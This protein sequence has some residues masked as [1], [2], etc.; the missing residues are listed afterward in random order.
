MTG[1]WVFF[2][3]LALFGFLATLF[4]IPMAKNRALRLGFVDYPGG[5][6]HHPEPVPLLG[7]ITF[8]FPL[9]CVLLSLYCINSLGGELFER[10][11]NFLVLSLLLGT[12]WILMLGTLD[13]KYCLRWSRKLL[14]QLAGVGILV[15]GGHCIEGAAVPFIGPVQ[16]GWWGIPLFAVV[17]I[18]ITNAV[19][20]IDGLDGF[21]AGV[22]MFA[23]L[24]VAVIGLGKG[25][26][27]SAMVG[28]TLFGSLLAFL[29]YNF[30]PATIY[31]GDGGS[32]ALGF[33]LAA[34][35]C[36][37]TAIAPGQRSGTMAVILAPFLPFGIA[38][39]DVF[40][41]IMRR[42]ISGRRIYLPD[43]EHI[44][45][46][47][48]AS[49]NRPRLVVGILYLFTGMLSTL[50]ILLVLGQELLVPV[51]ILVAILF[52][53]GTAGLLKLY[54]IDHL[55]QTIANRP[56]LQFLDSFRSFMT[57]RINRAESIE[58]LMSLLESGI[59]DLGFDSVELIR[60]DRPVGRWVAE[61]KVHPDSNRTTEVRRFQNDGVAIRWTVPRHDSD[62]YQDC[63]T[64]TWH[65]FLSEIEARHLV[66]S[67][68]NGNSFGTITHRHQIKWAG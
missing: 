67:A 19:N 5:R 15:C 55:S 64:E 65:H 54:R 16:F 29:G 52:L 49:F 58:E 14:G 9:L 57:K 12:A 45:H 38:L 36:G 30:P 53:C 51:A 63:L 3:G 34:L 59:R 20:L 61:W 23:S 21:A 26:V 40:L 8:V 2:G 1:T 39:L 46:R 13:D 33:F 44:H 66:L 27:F 68:G 24:T 18:G 50:S 6:K 7:G 11:K 35:A 42:W 22:C 60:H 37:S 56:H 48:M 10:P 25:D 62:S 41:A 28:F 17:V 47:L 31:M 32:L 43:A 4:S